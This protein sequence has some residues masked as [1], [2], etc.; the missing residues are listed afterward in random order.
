MRAGYERRRRALRQALLLAS[1][2]LHAGLPAQAQ[3]RAQAAAGNLGQA[4]GSVSAGSL[5]AL[6]PAAPFWLA[7][8]VLLFGAGA[9]YALWGTARDDEISLQN[10]WEVEYDA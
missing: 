10:M 5:F 9:A 1:L 3:D 7:A 2:F 8:I 6:H 4:L